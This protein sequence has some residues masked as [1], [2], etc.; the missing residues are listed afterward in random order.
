MRPT[1]LAIAAALCGCAGEID[2]RPATWAYIA[3]SIIIPSC[4]TVSCHSQWTKL[5]DLRLDTVD[6]GYQSL[7]GGRF[8]I[9]G[10]PD[11]S[12]LMF[13]LRGRE[14]MLMPPDLRLPEAD[15][16]LIERWILE[17]AIRQ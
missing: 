7:L 14:V 9:P 16:A 3:P 2:E 10:Q 4:G 5:Y 13:L 1:L 6:A 17:G 15:I 11:Q 8:V 12:K